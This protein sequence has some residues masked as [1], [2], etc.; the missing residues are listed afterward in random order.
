M[1]EEGP[2][3]G[4]PI[5]VPGCWETYPLTRTYRGKASYEKDFE[6]EGHIRLAFEGVSHTAEVFLDG[7]PV[8]QHYNA[9]TPFETVIQSEERISDYAGLLVEGIQRSMEYSPRFQRE[10]WELM[11]P[12]AAAYYD[13][14]ITPSELVAA[15]PHQIYMPP[16]S[17]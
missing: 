16:R 17:L 7:Q 12:S 14:R 6:A 1:P 9:Y 2:S 5:A 13:W 15:G 4:F 3:A 11:R 10:F 8:A